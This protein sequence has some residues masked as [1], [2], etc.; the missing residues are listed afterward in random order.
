MK[1]N[2]L[3]WHEGVEKKLQSLE[4]LIFHINSI[5]NES[6]DYF[7]SVVKK[8]NL[9]Y[10]AHRTAVKVLIIDFFTLLNH[11][12]NYNLPGYIGLCIKNHDSIDWVNPIS[13]VRLKEIKSLLNKLIKSE[14]F[15]RLSLTR[16]KYYAHDDIDK[17]NFTINIAYENI[18]QMVRKCQFIFNEISYPLTNSTY[19]FKFHDHHYELVA[20][21][22]FNQVQDYLD[23]EFR[24]S[25][26]LGVL[27]PIYEIVYN[28]KL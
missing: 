19:Y 21:H 18:W 11:K 22:R 25:H 5:F 12:E 20:L 3:P 17:H 24:K 4:Y 1:I 23:K 10:V 14:D 9:F 2:I 16:N 27:Q 13:L 6:E 15:I 28:V 7:E 8:S 26:N